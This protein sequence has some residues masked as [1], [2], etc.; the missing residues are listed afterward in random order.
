MDNFFEKRN[1]CIVDIFYRFQENIYKCNICNY[2][3]YNFQGFSVLNV[4]IIKANNS[5]INSLEESIIQYQHIQNH[6]NE[7][8]FSCPKCNGFNISTNA[9]I[10]SLPKTL[11]IN[12][13]RIGE[14]NFYNHNVQITQELKLRNLVN[15]EIYEYNLIG[16]IKHYGGGTS[17][18]NIAICKN[19][20]MVFGM[21]SMI[22]ES[23]VFGIQIISEEIK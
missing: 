9:R 1:S 19:F 21:S 18:H 13:K 15:N 23:V 14:N 2:S 7:R 16:C 12:F 17:G 20:L 4:P 5:L 11:L 10:I 8:G 6:F 3:R 22:L